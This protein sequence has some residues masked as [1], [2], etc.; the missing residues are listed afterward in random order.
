[1]VC[2]TMGYDTGSDL[3][4]LWELFFILVMGWDRQSPLFFVIWADRLHFSLRPR[5]SPASFKKTKS[6]FLELNTS[7]IL[8]PTSCLSVLLLLAVIGNETRV[9]LIEWTC[10]YLSVAMYPAAF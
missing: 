9:V 6:L 2:S 8:H 10:G 3:A 7:G 4:G 5:L 1:M